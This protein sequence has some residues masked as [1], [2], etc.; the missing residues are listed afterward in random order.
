MILSDSSIKL[1]VG[2]RDLVIEPFN[3]AHVQ[4]SSY[5]LTL[6]GDTSLVLQRYRFAL[7]TTAEWVELP[8]RIQGQVHGRSSIGRL[9]VLVHFT[10]GLIDPGFKG[11]ITLECMA[12]DNDQIFYPGDRI[13][14]IS[15]HWLDA[16]AESPYHGRYQGQQD[17]VNSRASKMPSIAGLSTRQM[18]RG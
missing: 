7:A 11:R 16:P 8:P 9:G 2:E 15:F 1:Y 12:L 3:T 14:Q 4:A 13:A 10:A 17:A 18:R 6:S 5:D